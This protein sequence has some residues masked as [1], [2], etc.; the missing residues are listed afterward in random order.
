VQIYL[1]INKH[2]IQTVKEN[3]EDFVVASKG[4][5]LEVNADKSNYLVT[6]R[7]QNTG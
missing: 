2:D 5:G 1:F 7:G 4:I 6:S 3:V